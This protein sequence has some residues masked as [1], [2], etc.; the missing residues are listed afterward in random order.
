MSL[1]GFCGI[2]IIRNSDT[3]GMNE[4]LSPDV[5]GSVRNGPARSSESIPPLCHAEGPGGALERYA[6]PGV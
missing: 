5:S 1:Y 4:K 3:N 6:R 2:V